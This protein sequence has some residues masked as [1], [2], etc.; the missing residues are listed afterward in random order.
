M[1]ASE[2]TLAMTHLS[3]GSCVPALQGDL[4][5]I[6]VGADLRAEML[7][8]PVARALRSTAATLLERLDGGDRITPVVCSDLW[9][10]NARDLHEH[11]V[12]AVG[13]P[14]VNA[15]TAWLA[16]RIPVALVLDDAFR[17]H[18]DG[19]TEPRACLWGVD[20]ETTA[21]AAETFSTRFLPALLEMACDRA[22][23]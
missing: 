21:G 15:A 4:L 5:L 19:E 16:T 18:F 11:A 17:I 20:R 14:D 9:Y 7:D 3:Q 10:V 13:G 23:V 12:V 1:R 2:D 22:S 6:V 8:R